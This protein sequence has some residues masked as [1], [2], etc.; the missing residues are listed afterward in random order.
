MQVVATVGM[1]G[2][3]KG[4]FAAVA[5]EMGYPVVRMG[6]VIRD[7]AERRGVEPSDANLGAI[8]TALREEHGDDVIAR[9]CVDAVRDRDAD[10]VVVDGVRGI[11]E[12]ETFR[13]AFGDDL[14][15]V[16]VEAPFEDRLE[17]LDE[18]GRSDDVSSEQA[19]ERRDE[20]ELGYGM[21]EAIEAA[22][23][24]VA[25]DGSLAAFRERARAM[26]RKVRDDGDPLVGGSQ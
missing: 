5:D 24:T 15:L 17:R 25:N 1:P 21:G 8:A 19:L 2:S 14:A 18:R 4:E 3:G 16:A 10:L 13:D 26:L 9:R 11:D 6:D 7:E 12:V 20:R 23:A 22:D